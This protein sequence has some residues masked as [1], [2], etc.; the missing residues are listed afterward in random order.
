MVG[1]G[2]LKYACQIL[3]R[4]LKL[5]DKVEFKGILPPEE[6]LAEM[7]KAR[8]YVQHSVTTPHGDREGTPVTI[9]EASLS[10]L[11]VV[12]T[13]HGG[14]PDVILDEETGLLCDEADINQMAENMIR[15]AKDDDLVFKMGKAG[16][17]KIRSEF[18]LGHYIDKVWKVIEAVTKE[19]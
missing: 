13:R 17:E 15:F 2:N 4:A 18:T 10:G 5:E 11:P 3:V 1:D 16:H 19:R 14:I 12:S 9:M 8:V 7:H 6:V